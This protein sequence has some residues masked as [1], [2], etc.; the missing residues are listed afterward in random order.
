METSA[1]G[2]A[3]N[4]QLIQQAFADFGSGNIQGILNILADDVVWGGYE[5]PTVPFA[6]TFKGKEGVAQFFKLLSD[7]VNFTRFEPR[8]FIG[9]GER[10][11]ALGYNSGTAK[12]MGKS[13]ESEWSFVF[14]VHNGKLQS[15]FGYNDSLATHRAFE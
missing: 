4:V 15:F 14:T 5:D 9:Q 12:K 8:E 6:R 13:F 2:G 11:V 1:A 3:N 7:S 10:V